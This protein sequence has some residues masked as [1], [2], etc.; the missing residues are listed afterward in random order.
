[1]SEHRAVPSIYST[2]KDTGNRAVVILGSGRSGTSLCAKILRELGVEM[3]KT[4]ERPNEMNPEGYF[5]DRRLVEINKRILDKLGASLEFGPLGEIHRETI[6]T[7]LQDLRDH[8]ADCSSAYPKLWGFKD[9]RVSLLLPV[10]RSAFQNVGIVPRYVF[11]A[12]NAGST[13]ESLH[14][15]TGRSREICEWTYFVRSYMALRDSAANCYVLHYEKL[16]KAPVEQIE[17]LWS[18]VGDD[19]TP[20]PLSPEARERLVERKYNRSELRA[21]PVSNP[22][23]GRIASLIN[24][25]EGSKFN[26]DTVFAELREIDSINS[27]YELRL[28]REIEVRLSSQAKKLQR[29]AIQTKFADVLNTEL[30]T[31][32]ANVAR[33][34]KERNAAIA[35]SR[36][37]ETEVKKLA[38]EIE[39][40]NAERARFQ[41]PQQETKREKKMSKKEKYKRSIQKRLKRLSLP[42]RSKKS[43]P[44]EALKGTTR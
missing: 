1:M 21:Q 43:Q 25:L 23:A 35:R 40:L 2:D 27:A 17:K 4:L 42:W 37:N 22:L 24:E 12:R 29:N 41:K 26:R 44:G 34:D 6:S 15:A 3:E 30:S 18:Y 11:C 20:C 16:L 31:L 32:Q 8:L 39:R 10:Y 38:R 33:L 19:A 13:V 9:P 5:E 28:Q 36:S 14:Q 7:E